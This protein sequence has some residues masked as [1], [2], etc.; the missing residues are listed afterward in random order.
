MVRLR[1]CSELDVVPLQ[2]D[3]SG[4]ATLDTSPEAVRAWKYEQAAERSLFR[5]PPR[6]P[7]GRG[8]RRN[9]RRNR[10]RASHLREI[11]FVFAD[12]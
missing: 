6:V 11:G 4:V 9:P 8:R 3:E 1:R 12:G 10:P 2:E 7:P 5:T